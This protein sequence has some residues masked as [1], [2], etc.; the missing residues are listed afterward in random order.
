MK[1]KSVP[2][3]Y[4]KP[5]A[6]E[7]SYEQTLLITYRGTVMSTLSNRK[8]YELGTFPASTLNWRITFGVL[9][10]FTGVLAI[11]MPSIA[12]FSAVL[13]FAW[14][15]ILGGIFEIAHTFQR[16]D[17]SS[18]I[19]MLTVST[20]TLVFGVILLV[21]PLTGV[22]SLAVLIGSFLFGSGI[23]RTMLAFSLYDQ[24]GWGWVLFDGA[25]SIGLAVL[26]AIDWPRSSLSIIGM[27]IGISL[28]SAGI[29]RI[30]L[31]NKTY[32]TYSLLTQTPP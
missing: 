32:D 2:G 16:Q 27:I 30:L 13:V 29:W 17:K 9:L 15:L 5:L 19:W 6:T 12:A 31:T 18:F 8:E 4:L 23:A 24:K 14:L 21:T 28:I 7:I 3:F 20:L 1:P 25:L 26:I 11:F 22:A 10:I